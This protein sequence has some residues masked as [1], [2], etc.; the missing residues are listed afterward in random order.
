MG[1]DLV[2][3]TG[4]IPAR[5]GQEICFLA[6]GCRSVSRLLQAGADMDSHRRAGEP[7]VALR[8]EWFVSGLLEGR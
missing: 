8:V 3:G 6:F 7:G 2:A 5:N 1:G 4:S